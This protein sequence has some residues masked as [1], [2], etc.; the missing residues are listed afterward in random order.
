M[1]YYSGLET[2]LMVLLI[3]FCLAA[4]VLQI[5]AL[6][7]LIRK[8]F[9]YRKYKRKKTT[10][11]K[12]TKFDLILAI[13]FLVGGLWGI[14]AFPFMGKFIGNM[15]ESASGGMRTF[16]LVFSLLQ[17]FFCILFLMKRHKMYKTYGEEIKRQ[18]EER[19][20]QKEERK[21]QKGEQHRK[22]VVAN[23]SQSYFDGGLFSL[24]GWKILGFLI[25]LFTLG[26]CYPWAL[27]MSYGWEMNH[28]VIEG[29]R[30]KFHGK[31]A[32]L[33]GHWLLWIF[34]TIIT[35]GIY[36]FWL[37]IALKKWVVKNTTFEETENQVLIN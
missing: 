1:W 13:Y 14:I 19:Q 28:T 12:G 37:N 34:L 25:T 31:A 7:Y 21:R 26:I 35:L 15:N 9:A 16:S 10:E 20:K 6:I 30:L 36:F 27:C 32:S 29:K 22:P 8:Y 11:I 2:F 4:F 23:K 17:S 24:I 3:L 5:S 33:F 18:K